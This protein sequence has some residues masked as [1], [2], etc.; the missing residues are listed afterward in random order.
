MKRIFVSATTRDLGSYRRLASESLR[1]RGC[2]VD[3]QAIF[4]L[5]YL[6]IGEK[7]EKRIAD[8]DA[9][10]CL[11]GFAYGGEPSKRPPDQ[12]RRSYTQWEYFLARKLHKP[13][14]LLLAEEGTPFDDPGDRKPESKTLLQLQRRYRAEI[15]RDRDWK[16][17]ANPDQLRAELAELRFPWE[18][19]PP[20]HKPCNLP[21]VTLGTLFKGRDEFLDDLRARLG[22]P[23]GR[24]AAIV[25]RQAVHGL[26]GVGKTRAAIEYAWRSAGDYTALLF[27]SAPSPGELHANLANLVGVL[28]MKVDGRPVDQQAQEV[29][30]WLDAHPGWL[31]IVDNVDTDLAA[32]EVERLL[33]KLRAGHVLIT[34]RIANWSA[35]VEPLE[36]HVLAPDAAVAFLLERTPHRRKSADDAARAGV[37]A[38]ELDGLALAVDQAG[39]YID[40]LRLSFAEYL[41]RWEAKRPEVLGWHDLRLMQYPA[42]VAITWETTFAQLTE[43]ERRLLEVLAWLAPEPIPLFLFEAAPLSEAIAEPREALAGLA[44]YSLAQFDTTGDA[45][46]VHRLVQEISRRR[47]EAAALGPG[48]RTVL[49]AVNEAAKGNP[50]DVRAWPV[51]S[52]LAPHAAAVARHADGAGL[53]KPTARLMNETALYL[54]TRCQFQEAEPLYRRALAIDERSYGPDHPDVASALNNLAGLLYAT[55]RLAEAE[56]LYRRALAIS[57]RSY[58]PDHPTVAIRLNNLAE[59]LRATNRLAEA[60]P[61]Y[62]RALAIDERSYGPDHP[63]VAIR[64]NNLAELLRATNRLAEAE[65]LYRRALAIHERSY[66]PDHPDVAQG[67]NNLALLLQDTNRLAEAEP[68][69]R[70]ALAIRERSYG[71]DHPDVAESLNNLALLLRDTNRLAEAEPLYRRAL[72]VYERSYGPDHPDVATALNNLAGLLYATNRL[73]E[74]EPLYRRAM[75]IWENSLGGD[76]P[77]VATALNNLAELLRATDRLAEAEPLYRRALAIDERSYGPDHPE[78]A[79]DLNNLA[80]LL[81]ATNRLAEAEPL[82]RRAVQILI[83]FRR[84]TGHEHPNYRDNRANYRGLLEAM[85]R[86]PDQIERQLRE[87]DRPLRPEGA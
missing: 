52:A 38:R 61:L 12:P 78:V 21:M 25:S 83:E 32:R 13:V 41:A 3:D 6:E 68:L 35:G 46:V 30:H 18:G 60:E 10:V 65:P 50:S 20:D 75:A 69:Y 51:W 15:T 76:H 66:G 44:A 80:G 34:S 45:V 23:D 8:C 43:P 82:L 53:T 1:K 11:I 54:N 67:L 49:A 77:Q 58:G 40:K 63:T 9:V 28:G 87:L 33:A 55:N 24:A 47:G 59:L 71:P 48:L 17:F 37:I 2:V 5:T 42:S 29:L 27:I 26:G 57:E 86:T 4:N 62:R 56:P 7:L 81:E 85:G 22:V 64:L 16:S 19:P 73:A 31:L 72:E 84:T 70:R 36:V 79:T 74:A 14:Y 39:A